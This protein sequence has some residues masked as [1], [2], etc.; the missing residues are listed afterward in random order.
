MVVKMEVK[1]VIVV[2]SDL[3]LSVGK[4]AVQVA[5]AS[6]EAS[7]AARLRY[8]DV[9]RLWRSRGCKKVVLKCRDLSELEFL[10]RKAVSLSLPS[11]LIQD[12]GLTEV[13]PG[14]VTALGIG[15]YYSDVIDKVTGRLPL[16]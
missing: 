9:W 8:P 4:L 2:R 7:E 5:H 13:P 10:Y 6:V 11:A 1:Q 15:P 14:T 3:N 16:A 12:A